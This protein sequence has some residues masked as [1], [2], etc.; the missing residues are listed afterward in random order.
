V[1]GERRQN[2]PRLK[3]NPPN[4]PTITTKRGQQNNTNTQQSGLFST[5]VVKP[6]QISPEKIKKKRKRAKKQ[7]ENEEEQQEKQQVGVAA[8]V[9]AAAFIARQEGV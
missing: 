7:N 9:I 8:D 2:I 3:Q 1:R 5:G 6:Y 4:P